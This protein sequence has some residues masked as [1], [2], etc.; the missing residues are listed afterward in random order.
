M[1][2]FIPGLNG[3]FLRRTGNR[4]KRGRGPGLKAA[5]SKAAFRG[6]KAPA[7]SVLLEL[8][9][10]GF[11]HRGSATPVDDCYKALW[12][13]FFRSL[14]SPLALSAR[15]KSCTKRKLRSS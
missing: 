7:P 2:M 6:L 12:R 13:E 11:I 3:S 14:L 5:P 1:S 4:L 8:E 10:A 9:S 15:L